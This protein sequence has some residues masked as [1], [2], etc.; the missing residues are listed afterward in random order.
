M[1]FGAQ[2]RLSRVVFVFMRN[3]EITASAPSEGQGEIQRALGVA[4][5]FWLS[6]FSAAAVPP[7]IGVA[8]VLVP[9]GGFAI[10]GDVLAN[11]AAINTGDWTLG[12]NSGSGG[13]VLSAAGVP[14]NPSTTFHFVDP[15][16]SS[17]D[18]TFA[19]GL[20]WTDNP[21][22]WKYASGKPSS[23]TD[24]NNVLMHIAPD[25]QGHTWTVV[26]ADRASTSGDSYIDFEFL[27]NT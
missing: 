26:A 20:K 14:L 3:I 21:N 6:L 16:N 17:A 5:A 12:T 24:I 1:P 23:K 19:G 22:N 27:Q 2:S 9:A 13:A 18:E 11:I 4:I 25:A 15:Y 10:D 7:P 8:P